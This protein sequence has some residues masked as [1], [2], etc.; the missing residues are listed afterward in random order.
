M[1]AVHWF[2]KGLRIHDN[3]ALSAAVEEGLELRPVFILDPW[4][5]SNARVGGNRWRFLV[6]SLDDLNQSL[7]K[8]GTRLFV[9][10]GKPEDVFP[11]LMKDWNI[12]KLTWEIDTEPYAVK[13][14]ACIEEIAKDQNIKVVSK[15]GHTLYS[16]QLL[17]QKNLGRPPLTYQAMLALVSKMGDPPRPVAELSSLPNTSKLK[18]PDHWIDQYKLPLLK[19]MGLQP[20][21]MSPFTL[22]TGFNVQIVGDILAIVCRKSWVC[23]FEKPKTSP[24]SLEPSTTVLSPYLKFGCLSPRVMYFRLKEVNFYNTSIPTHLATFGQF[25]TFGLILLSYPLISGQALSTHIVWQNN[26]VVSKALET[27]IAFQY[28]YIYSDIVLIL[29]Y[30][31][32]N[33]SCSVGKTVLSWPYDAAGG[34]TLTLRQHYRSDVANSMDAHWGTVLHFFHIPSPIFFSLITLKFGENIPA[35]DLRPRIFPTFGYPSCKVALCGH[36]ARQCIHLH[37]YPYRV[38]DDDVARDKKLEQILAAC[39]EKKKNRLEKQ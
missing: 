38:R 6:Q 7:M 1:T 13:R 19:D 20:I 22:F 33:N 32:T 25:V 31:Q 30:L 11:K 36:I 4:F 37:H 24:N 23:K 17:L 18:D 27:L 8:L 10:R 21:S 26:S 39:S 35:S 2:R 15:V 14:D 5:V 16:T 29:H 28:P 34:P 12:K 3:P 9:I